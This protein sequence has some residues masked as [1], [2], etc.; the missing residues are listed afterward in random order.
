MSEPHIEHNAPPPSAGRLAQPAPFKVTVSADQFNLMDGGTQWGL[1]LIIESVNGVFEFV[2]DDSM[3]FSLA[4]VLTDKVA[5][6]RQRNQ[7]SRIE[8]PNPSDVAQFLKNHH[9][10]ERK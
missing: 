6:V 5:V 7:M 1:K 4:E 8:V 9:K 10:P 3:G 2:M